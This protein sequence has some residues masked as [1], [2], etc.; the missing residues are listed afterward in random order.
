VPEVHVHITLPSYSFGLG[1]PRIA[2][3]VLKY[4]SVAFQRST[5]FTLPSLAYRHRDQEEPHRGASCPWHS[6]QVTSFLASQREPPTR[7]THR[8]SLARQG[9]SCVA[10]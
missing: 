4:R 10:S 5:A 2:P 8:S 7:G 1:A 3:G 6:S 9:Q